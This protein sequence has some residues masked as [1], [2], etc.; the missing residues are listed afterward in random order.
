M[1][2]WFIHHFDDERCL[3]ILKNC[4]E[5]IPV[6]GKVIVVDMLVPD[7]PETSLVG[8]SL[9][10]YELLMMYV[11]TGGKEKTRREFESL[12]K[13]TGFSHIQVPCSAYNISV[14]EFYKSF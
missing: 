12:A 4:Y 10:Q 6:N 2:Q 7:A 14:V 9:F 11:N 1:K 13:E 3:K 8:K 5:A